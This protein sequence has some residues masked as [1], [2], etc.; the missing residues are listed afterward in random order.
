MVF[1]SFVGRSEGTWPTQP[2][3]GSSEWG[4]D[5][6]RGEIQRI[7]PEKTLEAIKEIKNGRTYSLGREYDEGMPFVGGRSYSLIIP[8]S[9]PPVGDNQIMAFEEFVSTQL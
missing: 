4:I 8:H 3:R 2:E 9:A 6:E 5:D 7:T 1:I